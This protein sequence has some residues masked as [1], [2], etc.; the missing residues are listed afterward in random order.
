MT[1]WHVFLA[2][3]A[4]FLIAAVTVL[5]GIVPIQASSGHWR[6]TAWMLDLIK[7]RSV[8]FYSHK[9]EVPRLNEPS[10]IA[11]GAAHYERACRP[12]H[13]SPAADRPPLMMK[14]TPHPP[15]LPE[16]VARWT[17]AELFQIVKHGIKFTGM[18]SWPAPSRNDEV[19][20][21]VAFL[22]ILDDLT[23]QHYWRL[24]VGEP[25]HPGSSMPPITVCAACHG[26]D[27]LGRDGGGFPVLA[28]QSSGYMKRALDAYAEGIRYSGVMGQ[29]A[30]ALDPQAGDTVIAH[31][32]ALPP[33]AHNAGRLRQGFGAQG[34]V[35][36]GEALALRGA[37]AQRIPPCV[38]CHRR[39]DRHPDYPRLDGQHAD[40]L[41]LQLQ[42]FKEGR[43]GGSPLAEIMRPIAERLT[44]AQQQ[45]VAAYFA[46]AASAR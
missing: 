18:P 30:A 21:T 13:G 43:R 42:L 35:A 46:G 44:A 32:A 22:R 34:L 9:I 3:W 23:P 40:Y 8:D 31:Y 36:A 33:P 4:M 24:A 1:R 5:S 2:V 14:M 27:G 11:R 16:R 10:L 28:G 37:S 15:F 20:A 6:T 25:A 7:R 19:W 29:I 17:D 41:L 12:C 39:S 45:D 38:E 26:A